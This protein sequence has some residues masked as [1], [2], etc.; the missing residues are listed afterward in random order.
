MPRTTTLSEI[1]E[2]RTLLIPNRLLTFEEFVRM[3]G[4]DDDVELVDGMV[5]QR[6]A[7]KD[8]H[9]D[10]FRWL[11][12]LLGD[13][14]DMKGLGVVRGSRTPVKITAH[15]GRLPD[16]V[17]VRSENAHIVQEDGIF[18]APDLVIEIWSPGDKPS[19]MF[20][21]EADYRSIGVSEIW[22]ID[23]SK[24]QV[25]VLSKRGERYEERVM[26]RGVLRS[27]AV[28]GFWLKVEWLFKKPL[29]DEF[30][31]LNQILGSGS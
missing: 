23:Q 6:M 9:E 22:L 14:V 2:E 4:E 25:R 12:I 19:E 16:I 29:P 20:A 27:E 7:A 18:G 28:E 10:L 15:R 30:T 21:K 11:F 31:T 13:F 8:I 17:F 3:F 1:R 24:K 5:V 26:R